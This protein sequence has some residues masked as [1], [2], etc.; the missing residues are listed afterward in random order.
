VLIFGDHGFRL[1]RDGRGFTHGGPSTLE[2]LTAAA[3]LG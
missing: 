3:V 2:R 1:S